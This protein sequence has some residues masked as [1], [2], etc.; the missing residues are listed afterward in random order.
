MLA[1]LM[2]QVIHRKSATHPLRPRGRLD[3]GRPH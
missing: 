3:G 1:V 2:A